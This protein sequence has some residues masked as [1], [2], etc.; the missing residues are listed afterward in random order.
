MLLCPPPVGVSGGNVLALAAAGRLA[1]AWQARTPA[2][3]SSRAS[4]E[5][6]VSATGQQLQRCAVG[7]LALSRHKVAIS[8][9]AAVALTICH[10]TPTEP[11]LCARRLPV[12]RSGLSLQVRWTPP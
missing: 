4:A 9:M 8:T 11:M 5:A 3:Q 2:E 10:P 12:V 7:A 6:Q 1:V